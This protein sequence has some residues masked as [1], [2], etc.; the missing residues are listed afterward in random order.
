MSIVDEWLRELGAYTTVDNW[1]EGTRLLNSGSL[2]PNSVV[3]GE[4]RLFSRDALK[5]PSG[6][7]VDALDLSEL[8][9]K[10]SPRMKVGRLS[11]NKVNV[12]DGLPD[13][14]VCEQLD[15]RESN[16]REIP[17]TTTVLQR[18]NLRNC[19][20][21]K[22]LPKNLRI[23]A[24]IL[25]GCTAL[26]IL[27]EGLSVYFLDISGCSGIR[28]LPTRATIQYGQLRARNCLNLEALPD[29]LENLS[30]LDLQNCAKIG[31][32]PPKLK[33]S[34]WIDIAGTGITSLPPHMDQ[35]GVRWRGVPVDRRI[36]FHPET[37][38]SND[39]LQER[40]AE[41]RRVMLE[42][43]GFERF[44]ELANA[45]IL[46]ADLDKGG[47]RKLLRVAMQGDEAIVC[48]SFKCP[49]TGRRYVLRVP[50]ATH[51]AR[52]A[53]AWIAGFDNPNDYKPTLES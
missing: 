34:E 46:D 4:I 18:I 27:P 22:R 36:V 5:I 8:S 6:L 1:G 49:S 33:I 3:R 48:V 35:V 32:L 29:W 17:A 52:A 31:R 12:Q 26:E 44:M 10:L 53:V 16:L 24:L 42:R 7:I 41:V 51:T 13:D 25:R 39:I 37:I 20:E 15:V 11:L 14:L 30:G 38:T 2:P 21:I 50:P 45:E 43:V 28:A 23:N 19:T 47:E 9:V 40:N